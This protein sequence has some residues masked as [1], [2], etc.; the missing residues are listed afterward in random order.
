MSLYNKPFSKLTQREKDDE[1]A[2][3][4]ATTNKLKRRT[5]KQLANQIMREV[6]HSS[7]KNGLMLEEKPTLKN[8]MKCC[9]KGELAEFLSEAYAESW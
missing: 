1:V 4:V 7:I 6:D 8:L 3:F 9:D 5:K 2:S